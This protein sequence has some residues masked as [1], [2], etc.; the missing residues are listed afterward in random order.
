MK[1]TKIVKCLVQTTSVATNHFS[2]RV[3]Y[4]NMY[5]INLGVNYG[6]FSIYFHFQALQSTCLVFTNLLRNPGELLKTTLKK[7]EESL[8]PWNQNILK[9]TYFTAFK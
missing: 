7:I 3:I 5:F 6:A 8:V 1:Q 2:S 9:K 4:H